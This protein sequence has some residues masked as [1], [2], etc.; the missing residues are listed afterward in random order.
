M[1]NIF[2]ISTRIAAKNVSFYLTILVQLSLLFVWI[3]EDTF[4]SRYL[5][6]HVSD[7]NFNVE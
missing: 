5:T 2:F 3:V 4:Y 1:H 6:G 7:I